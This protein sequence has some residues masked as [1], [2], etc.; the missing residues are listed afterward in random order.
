MVRME[1]LQE[2]RG[3]RQMKLGIAGLQ[4]KQRKRSD[5]ACEKRCTLKNRMVRLGSLFKASI[6]KNRGEGRAENGELKGDGMKA[7]QLL[8]GRPPMFIG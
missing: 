7:G 2:A 3:V 4:C 1:A 5:D 8:S 6:P